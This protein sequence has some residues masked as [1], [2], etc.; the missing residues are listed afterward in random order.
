MRRGRPGIAGAKATRLAYNDGKVVRTVWLES[1]TSL[2]Y[3][4]R[5]A[6]NF[7]IR[8]IAIRELLGDGNNPEIWDVVS[9]YAQTAQV[10]AT[11]PAKDGVKVAW[12]ASGGQVQPA[13]GSQSWA[14]IIWKAPDK[15]GSYTLSAAISENAAATPAASSGGVSISV[16]IPTP[17]PTPVPPTPTPT[18]VP[19]ATPRPQVAVALPRPRPPR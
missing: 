13:A 4:L 2:A 7:S 1:G 19:T 17:T 11:E 3:K 8:G 12:N 9:L 16:K 14:S 5:E 18:R 6:L 15:E 10:N